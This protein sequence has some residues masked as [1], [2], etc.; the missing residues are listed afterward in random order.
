MLFTRL[1]SVRSQRRSIRFLVAF[2]GVILTVFIGTHSPS[3]ALRP[4]E[5]LWDTYGVPHI[6]AKNTQELF[7]A[8]GWA[9][10]QSHGNLVL[11][12]YGQARG[13]AAEYW[14]ETYLDSDRWVRTMGIPERSQTWYEAQSPEFRRYLD[15]FA[16][17]V[18]AYVEAHEEQIEDDMKAVLPIDGVDLLAHL[19]RVLYFT[20]IVDPEQVASLSNADQQTH[21]THRA[22]REA[23]GSN[24]WAIAPSHSA[25]GNALLLANPHL[26]WSD[27]FL[28]YEAQ[29]TAPGFDAYGAALV[30]TPV[31][32]IAFND[33]LGWSHTIN[34]FDGWD[35]YEL[36]L[37]NGGYQLDGKVQP[38]ETEEQIFYIKQ[39]NGR[40]R[41]E[42]LTI[43]H[44]VHGPVVAESADNAIALRVVGLDQPG[45]LEQWWE[46]ANA[47]NLAEF[48]VALQQMQIPMFTIIYAD[49]DGHILHLFN[50]QVPVR[51]QGDFEAWTTLIP[52]NTSDTMWTEMH[53]Y[54]D[55]PLVLDPPSGW[56]QNA[57]DAPWTTTFPPVLDPDD[58]PP[59]MAPRGPMWFRPQQSVRLLDG[60]PQI[61]L[62]ELIQYK[63]STHMELAEHLLDDLLA[64]AQQGS[65]L[66]RR[67]ADVLTTWD[68]C[69]D[70]DSRGAVLFAFWAK[71]WAEDIDSEIDPASDRLFAIPWNEASP[72]TTPDGLANP[73]DAV[74]ALETAAAQVE[75]SFG[76]LDVAWGDVFRLHTPD[77]NLPA[78]GGAS[79]L[80][81]FRHVWFAPQPDGTFAAIGGDSYVAAI[82]FSDPV[83]AM[84][85]T[86]YGNA[87][88]PGFSTSGDSLERFA[89]QELRPVWRSRSDIEAHL[90]ARQ[91][92]NLEMTQ[93]LE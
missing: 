41:E 52:G 43:R 6:E 12:L 77:K 58:Y 72:R 36:T 61:S 82:E 55:L 81:V 86:T 74:V 26:P 15:A 4:T 31:L 45:A 84:A 85:L 56:L 88:Q 39:D 54:T 38:F 2:I 24:A 3:A 32:E 35:G 51:S 67:A 90:A 17:G 9:Q 23:I 44:S 93:L 80:G 65:E 59:Y 70:A 11:R 57:N 10:T 73:A 16:A 34:T 27:L 69:A 68:R 1:L 7:Y 21:T 89:R 42:P 30:G 63:H 22:R 47:K 5:I 18:N 66:A 28:W 87:T 50:G 20:F 71:A 13:R 29:L 8:F 37:T 62:D 83:R 53:P 46:M 92:F 48:E 14:G 76:A 33:F 25:S 79:E 64:A 91:T 40:L 19:Q 49:R 78:N 75:S 60:D